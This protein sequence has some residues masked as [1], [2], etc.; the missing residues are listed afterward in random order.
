MILYSSIFASTIKVAAASNLSYA[1]N[2]LVEE[3]NKINPKTKVQITLG[4]SG[5]FAS[6]IIYGAPF[7]IF[8][9]ANMEFPQILYS[10]KFSSFKPVVY[11]QGSLV[12]ISAKKLDFSKNINILLDNSIQKIAI[13]NPKT[14][15]YGAASIEAIKNANILK[16]I[17]NKFVYAENI[18]QAVTYFKTNT[19]VAFI[20]KS[21][22]FAKNMSEYKE[23]IN[24]INIDTSLYAPIDQGVILL[25]NSKNNKEALAFY[26]FILS[27]QA[28][29]IFQKF[30]YLTK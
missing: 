23:N 14:A 12:M 3:F 21:A 2:E 19:D 10:K 22:L 25:S 18:S 24:W 29:I 13:A 30:G 7:D 5:K 17:Q 28:K 6:Q 9:S 16:E 8:L 26:N 27:N 1:I 15:P 11:A 4:S 20:A